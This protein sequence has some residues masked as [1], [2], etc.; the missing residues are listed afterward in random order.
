MTCDAQNEQIIQS[1]TRGRHYMEQNDAE[2]IC[3]NAQSILVFTSNFLKLYLP[4][5]LKKRVCTLK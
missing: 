4:N 2:T 3:E 1:V 5:Y